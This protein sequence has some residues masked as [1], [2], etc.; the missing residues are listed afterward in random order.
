MKSATEEIMETE[1]I[2]EEKTGMDMADPAD[3]DVEMEDAE[4][5]QIEFEELTEEDAR[6]FARIEKRFIQAYH[7]REETDTEGN[8]L[9]HQLQEE[10]PEKPETEIRAM[11]EEIQTSVAEA[12]KNLREINAACDAGVAKEKWFADKMSEAA[13]GMSV[14][15]FGGYLSQIDNALSIGNEQMRRTILTNAGEVSQCMNLDGFIAEQQAVNSFNRQAVLEGSAFR[16]EVKVPGPGETYGRNSFDTVIKD[17]VTGET[18]HQ[19]QFKF[20]KDAESTIRMLKDGNYNNQRFVVPEEQVEAVREAFPGKTVEAYMGGTEKVPTKSDSLSK[21][22]VKQMQ[23]EVQ[24][25]GIMPEQNWNSYNTK[26]LAMHVG[27]EAAMSGVQAMAI[28][29]GFVMAEKAIKGEKIDADETVEIALKT[30]ADTWVKE[31]TAGAVKVGAEKGVIKFIP[32]GTPAGAIVKNVS[33]AIEDIKILH[34]VAKKE[35]SVEEGM[36]RI[37]R[38]TI[39]MSVGLEWAADGA[40]VGMMIG[41]HAGG[42]VGAA[43][44]SLVGGT[45]GY[46]AGS[47]VG[48]TIYNG[49]KKIGNAVKSGVKKIASGVKSVGSAIGSGIKSIER[50]VAGWFGR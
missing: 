17:S 32:P 22:Q 43:V 15:E 26:E 35:M 7:D 8:W 36:D 12:E 50:S 42:P 24:E 19:Y 13:S 3:G 45:V 10:L 23:N 39:A 28:T 49:A 21:E 31:A 34:K 11:T 2:L 48:Q 30:G 4:L 16:A 47:K 27:K 44:G 40:V 46:I 1:E 14:M 25:Q 9:F 41:F 18:V 38:T 33:I 37:A 29:T 20:G 5:P 6:E